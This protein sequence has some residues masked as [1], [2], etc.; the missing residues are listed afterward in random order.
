MAFQAE[1]G[2][3][4]LAVNVPPFLFILPGLVHHRWFVPLVRDCGEV[5]LREAYE[6]S[7]TTTTVGA[8]ALITC[9]T[10]VLCWSCRGA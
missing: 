10:P 7:V 8:V 9:T 4:Q 3:L 1:Y 5:L 2:N 6:V